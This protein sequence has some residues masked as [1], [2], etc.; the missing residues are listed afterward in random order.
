MFAKFHRKLP[1]KVRK[2]YEGPIRSAVKII[3][4]RINYIEDSNNFFAKEWPTS[5]SFPKFFKT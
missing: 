1:R 5:I 4:S 2:L 3:N